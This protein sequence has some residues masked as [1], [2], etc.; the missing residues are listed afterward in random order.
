MLL[1]DRAKEL[2]T[3]KYNGQNQKRLAHIYGVAEMAEFLANRYGVDKEK[4]LVAA[5]MHDYS[6]YDDPKTAV[7]ILSDEEI[8]ECEEF[9]FLYHAYLS[10]YMYKK[11]LGNDDDIYNA[12]KYHVFGRTNMSMLEAIIM[13]A[14]YTEKNRVY[15]S[16]CY[17]RKILVEDNDLNLAIYESLKGTIEFLEKEGN[18]PHPEQIKVMEEYK[19]KVLNDDIRRSACR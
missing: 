19:R 15:P 11:L 3:L 10:A 16:C 17:V 4:A 14:D 6:K 12:I 8:K 7:G 5:Y 18:K 13:I 2:V 1:S 9:P